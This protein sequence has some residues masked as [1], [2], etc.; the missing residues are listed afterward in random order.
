MNNFTLKVFRS[1]DGHIYP[2]D[3]HYH[4]GIDLMQQWAFDHLAANGMY[5]IAPELSD[6]FFDLAAAHGWKIEITEDFE[7]KH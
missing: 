6:L 3:I 5:M 2:N 7:V 4:G 1:K